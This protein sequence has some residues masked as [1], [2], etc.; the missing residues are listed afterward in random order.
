MISGISGAHISS[1][2]KPV[3]SV[4]SPLRQEIKRIAEETINWDSFYRSRAISSE[5]FGLLISYDVAP[6][7]QRNKLLQTNGYTI[8]RILYGII[9]HEHSGI[10]LKY[11]LALIYNMLEV[12]LTNVKIF[13]ECGREN[14][15]VMCK[16]YY[17]LVNNEDLFIM[18]ISGVIFTQLA[19]WDKILL[20]VESMKFFFSWLLN[21]LKDKQYSN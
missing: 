17:R 15:Y 6:T 7:G 9:S 12:N 3:L 13:Y 19:S 1:Q 20:E 18:H 4:T 11:T 14:R 8:A 21:R 5:E 2:Y 10:M 16:P